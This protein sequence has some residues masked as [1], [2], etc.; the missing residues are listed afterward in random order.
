MLMAVAAGI[1][2][3]V[4]A[5][6]SEYM[7]PGMFSTVPYSWDFSK[8]DDPQGWTFPEGAKHKLPDA[9][10]GDGDGD[11]ETSIMPGPGQVYYGDGW[12]YSSSEFAESPELD[13]T[14]FTT[15]MLMVQTTDRWCSYRWY[16]VSATADGVNW[17]DISSYVIP[18]WAKK[19][20]VKGSFDRGLAYLSF[21]IVDLK[22]ESEYAL[23]HDQT[24]TYY[25]YKDE[26]PA[27]TLMMDYNRDG[28]PDGFA[29]FGRFCESTGFGYAIYSNGE[30]VWNSLEYVCPTRN[31][32]VFVG[33]QSLSNAFYGDRR[34]TLA[35][36]V[37]GL[38]FLGGPLTTRQTS[39]WPID[40]DDDGYLDFFMPKTNEVL[41]FDAECNVIR[42]LLPVYREQE[43]IVAGGTGGLVTSDRSILSA[44]YVG[45][46][47]FIGGGD[48]TGGAL[49]E[50]QFAGVD[51]DGNGFTDFV[52]FADGSIYYNVGDG[53]YLSDSFSGQMFFTD[54]N[55][56]GLQDYVVYDG[57]KLALHLRNA[58]GSTTAKNIISGYTCSS[59]WCRDVDNDGDSDLILTL[60]SSQTFIVVLENTGNGSFRRHEA[61]I[62]ASGSFTNCF[63]IDNDGKYELLLISRY[64][65]DAPKCFKI[66]GTEPQTEP[67]ELPGFGFVN[68]ADGM[69]YYFVTEGQPQPLA[70]VAN[71]RPEAPAEAPKLIYEASTGLLKVTWLRGTDRETPA[72]DLTYSVRV[73]TA[74]GLDDVVTAMASPS[75]LRYRAA[76]GSL[77]TSTEHIFNTSGWPAGKLYVSV[78]AVDGSYQGSPFSA[79]AVFEKTAP[80][81]DFTVHTP[82]DNCTV[83]DAVVLSL[84]FVPA[85]GS[86]YSWVLDGAT[87]LSR[88]ADGREITVAFNTPGWKTLT[89]GC[90]DAT[91]SYSAGKKLYVEP[92]PV[93]KNAENRYESV[94]PFVAFDMDEDGVPEVYTYKF[95]KGDSEGTYTPIA[96]MF[97]NHA[98]VVNF[99]TSAGTFDINGDGLCDIVNVRDGWLYT[100][101]N[102]DGL[103]MEFDRS[104]VAYS[105]AKWVDM[106]NDGKYDLV[107]A[108][109]NAH[110]FR[111][112]LG[113][114]TEFG[115]AI[116]ARGIMYDWNGDGLID[117]VDQPSYWYTE[118]YA[119]V[120][121]NNG[122][123]T[124]TEAER[125]DLPEGY[126]LEKVID[127][128]GNGRPD[129]II[130]G[131]GLSKVLWDDGAISVIGNVTTLYI[132]DFDNDGLLDICGDYYNWYNMQ[133]PGRVFEYHTDLYSYLD[134]EQFMR[135]AD[136]NLYA[137][138]NTPARIYVNNGRPSAPAGLRHS[139]G[140]KAVVIEWDAAS[141]RETRP[142]NMRYN[143]S[144]K[145]KGAE[146]EGAYLIS[147]ANSGK[148]GVTL[149]MTK[150]L[151]AGT[152]FTIPVSN[153]PAGDYEV[154]VQAVDLMNDC[155]DFSEVYDMTVYES[156]LAEVPASGEVNVP[157]A[158]KVLVNGQY[159]VDYDGGTEVGVNGPVHDIVWSTSG[160]KTVT[161]NGRA[162]TIDIREAPDGS[163]TLPAAACAGDR[164]VFE[165]ENADMG[166][167]Y[168][169]QRV[170]GIGGVAEE[171]VSLTSPNNYGTLT[172]ID[173]SHCELVVKNAAE[174]KLH[175][176]VS[177][178]F[179]TQEFT[180]TMSVGNK[181]PLELTFVTADHAT[182]KY[183]L[184]WPSAERQAIDGITV[185][186]ETSV[187]GQYTVLAEL[188]ATATEYVDYTSTP[189]V[190]AAR[191]R[192]AY[193]L[194][195]GESAIGTAHQPIHVMLNRSA[196]SAW[197]LIWG[198][199]EGAEV[200]QYRILRGSSPEAMDV[201]A[202]VSGNMMSYTDLTAPASG[203]LYYAV[204]SV[205]NPS[206]AAQ[207]RSRAADATSRSNVVAAVGGADIVAAQS[208]KVYAD[209]STSIDASE[210]A[211]ACVQLRAVINPTSATYKRVNWVVV[212]G[213]DI[214]TVDRTGCVRP[215]NLAA[216][217]ATVRAMAI[218]GSGVF[219]DV[220]ITV[221]A[222]SGIEAPH[223]AAATALSATCS[224][225][226][227]TIGGL[228]ASGPCTLYV[229]G[230]GGQLN[231]IDRNV[232]STSLTID[233]RGWAPGVYVAKAVGA[234]GNASAVKF[235]K[236]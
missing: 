101:V 40:F 18:R 166:E 148:N 116:E 67:E 186:K 76:D 68:P 48:G 150:P 60:Q 179:S 173:N 73:G 2:P 185:Y 233:C 181:A 109:Y 89:L 35:F 64:A 145:R 143:L 115:S 71:L 26:V 70:S 24:V 62:S 72:L 66:N 138:G 6:E 97:N 14:C 121:I 171:P 194:T 41:N 178:E 236:K 9:G 96:R 94:G 144:V 55:G 32:N 93:H 205:L 61:A 36:T 217:K 81:L 152:R 182:G 30:N 102:T 103:D 168:V 222:F 10:S 141:D 228:P 5:A 105:V 139:Q 78:Q 207:A 58:D 157:V 153:I 232:S 184:Q 235:I 15:P 57:D 167:W 209:G 211:D 53:T 188:P 79:E 223:S 43:E 201:I 234:S 165:A 135:L 133:R 45:S 176:S 51:L 33:I 22:T 38:D 180:Q 177:S 218:D 163:F 13:L 20:R 123:C 156:A 221:T 120:Y 192:L 206:G 19:I 160:R 27:L 75:G 127:L 146:G 147:P 226:V 129:L 154:M 174:M 132:A 16:T 3:G 110:E 44:A 203:E 169:M 142:A 193:R 34:E 56:D 87:E 130:Q 39:V 65:T 137:N 52:N 90:T 196:G 210:N 114:Y 111:R 224:G 119:Q 50:Q 82:Y 122:D 208:I 202:E 37:P 99:G 1:P 231:Y 227:L 161:L 74:P 95:M 230:L 200:P 28:K 106:D 149:P 69:A 86:E 215:T 175:H 31:P 155:G 198:K 162:M 104:E 85:S 134:V 80:Q 131:E 190:V 199:Y 7:N 229:F 225:G 47:M 108:E 83:Y 118:K 23:A 124:F 29:S 151:V 191:Y 21:A 112:N 4:A 220:E 187:S 8:S 77:G 91:G 183:L 126:Y 164:I 204:E 219:D 25:K 107:S 172:V 159:D 98:Y 197:N 158:V 214:V 84:P 113:D 12:N 213:D 88:S 59:I 100:G 170:P 195:Y 140:E 125:I 189:D 212:S 42:S 49:G 117:L 63:D 17:R 46:Q 11:G 92:L 136:G 216:G 54:F 128:D